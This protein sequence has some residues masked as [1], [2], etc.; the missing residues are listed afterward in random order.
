MSLRILRTLAFALAL[1]VPLQ[2]MAAVMGGQCM[3]LGHHEAAG[4]VAAHDHHAEDGE[5][6]DHGGSPRP[7]DAAAA[8]EGADGT[9]PHCGPCAACCASASIAGPAGLPILASMSYPPF[10]FLPFAPSG[11]SPD[12]LERPPHTL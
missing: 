3:A 8:H 9:G 11:I 2:A 6:H 10:V 1:V 12:G 4:S 7:G 5:G